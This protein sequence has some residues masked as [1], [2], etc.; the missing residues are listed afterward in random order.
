MCHFAS[1]LT[2]MS[3]G[4]DFLLRY[5]EVN[6]PNSVMYLAQWKYHIFVSGSNSFVLAFIIL[7]IN[8]C[9]FAA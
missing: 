2:G 5:I 3:M 1:K 7:N 4:I 9:N 6:V 8:W